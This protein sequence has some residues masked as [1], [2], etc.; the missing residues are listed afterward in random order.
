MKKTFIED[1]AQRL[2][3][4]PNLDREHSSSESGDLRKYPDPENWHDHIAV[5]YTHLTLPT[6]LLV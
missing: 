3:I 1:I 6:I 4:I 5:S 2:R